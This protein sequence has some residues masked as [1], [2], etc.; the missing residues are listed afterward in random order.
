MDHFVELRWSD[1]TRFKAYELW[2]YENVP[3]SGFDVGVREGL[4]DPTT[5]PKP[6]MLKNATVD[7]E[8]ALL[9]RWVSAS[10]DVVLT[11]GPVTV[12]KAKPL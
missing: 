12:M 5:L 3:G 4:I 1:G 10:S 8:G 9:L 11:S 7:E 6:G 2:L